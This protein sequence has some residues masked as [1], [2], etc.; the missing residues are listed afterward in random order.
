MNQLANDILTELQR[1]DAEHTG[2]V[3]RVPMG[4]SGEA[5]AAAKRE[6]VR[7]LQSAAGWFFCPMLGSPASR[8][9]AVAALEAAGLVEADGNRRGRVLRLTEA[10]R[11]ATA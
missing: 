11:G 10:G 6:Q 2:S 7:N 1:L 9:R 5:Y 4:L 3:P 8:C